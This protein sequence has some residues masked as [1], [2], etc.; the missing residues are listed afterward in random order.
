MIERAL[1]LIALAMSGGGLAWWFRRVRRVQVPKNRTPFVLWM[2]VSAAFA[3]SALSEGSGWSVTL[4]ASL[5]LLGASFALLTISISRQ[6]T[7]A[8]VEVGDS[9]SGP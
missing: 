1:A 9:I 4:L 7:R 8:A 6:K 2:F 3:G 5:G